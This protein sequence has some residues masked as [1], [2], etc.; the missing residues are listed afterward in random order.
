MHLRDDIDWKSLNAK[1]SVI[2][3]DQ[4]EI[5]LENFSTTADFDYEAKFWFSSDEGT[6]SVSL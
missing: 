1:M 5:K 6:G 4:I 3:D 2:K